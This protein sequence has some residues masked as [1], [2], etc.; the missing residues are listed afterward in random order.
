MV[1]ILSEK[2]GEP[3]LAHIQARF[4]ILSSIFFLFSAR[5]GVAAV[6]FDRK[7]VEFVKNGYILFILQQ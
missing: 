5:T 2:R 6:I 3:S 1:M 4:F 7:S